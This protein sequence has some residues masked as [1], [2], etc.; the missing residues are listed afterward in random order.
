[1]ICGGSTNYY[2]LTVQLIVVLIDSLH[3]ARTCSTQVSWTSSC[4]VKLAKNSSKLNKF[5]HSEVS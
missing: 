2:K 4:I 5:L 3:Y 1:M